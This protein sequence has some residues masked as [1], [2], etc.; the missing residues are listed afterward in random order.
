MDPVQLLAWNASVQI[1]FSSVL[2]WLMLFPRQPWGGWKQRASAG[3]SGV[4]SLLIAA[5]GIAITVEG[6][7]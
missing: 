2:G 7:R 3:L 1:A 5:A 4:S 6:W